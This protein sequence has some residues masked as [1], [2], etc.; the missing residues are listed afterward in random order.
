MG[1]QQNES[2]GPCTS[3]PIISF[4]IKHS[5]DNIINVIHLE[6]NTEVREHGNVSANRAHRRN[7]GIP[8]NDIQPEY[9]TLM[10]HLQELCG[11][12]LFKTKW[13]VYT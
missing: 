8:P 4:R 2:S 6:D 9:V 7:L 12:P 10:G 1:F 11:L 13:L 5:N 3:L